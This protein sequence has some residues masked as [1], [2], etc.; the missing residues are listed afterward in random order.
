MEEG[1][2]ID[3]HVIYNN[4]VVVGVLCEYDLIIVFCLY[5][6]L[7]FVIGVLYG[8]K[9]FVFVDVFV[10]IYYVFVIDRM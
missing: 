4:C 5:V 2:G 7:W 9:K 10:W 3:G 6:V 8:K 1:D